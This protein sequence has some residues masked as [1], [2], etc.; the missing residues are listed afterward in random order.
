MAHQ[1]SGRRSSI[2]AGGLVVAGLAGSVAWVV[3]GGRST[4]AGAPAPTSV[5]TGV[6]SVVRADVAERNQF[7]GSEGYVGSYSVTAPAAGTLT[8]APGIGQVVRQGQ[9]LYEVD[10]TPVILM[11][12][13]RPVW[14]ALELGMTDG[15]DVAQLQADLKALGY[16]PDLTVSRQFSWATYWAICR[17]Q[18]A[19]GLP[20]T[21]AVPLGQVA[22]LPMAVRVASQG[23]QLGASVQPGSTVETDTSDQRAVIVE[24]PPAD[25]PTTRVGDRV[26]V[27]LPDGHTQRQ[28]RITAIGAT[29]TTSGSSSYA[30][31]SGGSSGS[32]SGGTGSQPTA[33]VTISMNGP[34]QGFI[35]QA[36]VQ[37]FITDQEHR[38]VLAVPIVSLRA[39]P[40][41]QYRVVVVSGRRTRNV[42][43]TAGLFDDIAGLAEVSGPG[44][45]AGQQVEVPSGSA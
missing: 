13:R 44:L 22:F 18:A 45:A 15:P 34:I 40:G 29:A 24:L 25:L 26:M 4:S 3:L 31:G 35:D 42:P 19:A 2:V 6:A 14:R 39:L 12:G 7:S 32:G 17:W 27:L 36:Q 28:G 43:V 8:L 10:G 16:G 21:G 38:N 5:Q 23:A 41:G 20:V 1:N 33:Q 11:Y 9:V 37:V 30:S